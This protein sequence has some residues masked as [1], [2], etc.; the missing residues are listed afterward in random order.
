MTSRRIALALPALALALATIPAAAQQPKTQAAAATPALSGDLAKIQGTWKAQFGPDKQV[1]TMVVQGTKS[2]IKVPA[3]DGG[4]MLMVAEVKLDEAASPRKWDS[5]KR[6]IDGADFPD[7]E[8]IYKLDG[9]RL[10]ICGGGPGL[11]RPVDFQASDDGQVTLVV[12]TRV[13]AK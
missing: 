5:V 11:P 2:T 4:D 6:K 3:A 12:F 13:K 1:L 7:G 10:T 9:D 8:A